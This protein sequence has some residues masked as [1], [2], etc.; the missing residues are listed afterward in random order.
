MRKVIV[1]VD[2]G[3]FMAYRVTK[4]PFA[5]SVQTELIES[6][7]SIEAR[8]KLSDTLSDAAGRFRLGQGKNGTVAGYGEAHNIELEKEK[9]L[10][11]QIAEDINALI[12][13]EKC[14]KWYLA[15]GRSINSQIVEN[16]EPAVRAKLD[17]NIPCNLTKAG[18]SGILRHFGKEAFVY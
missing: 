13:R 5:K 6:Y 15:A 14:E 4:D 12:T 16:L 10:V 7:D 11:K 18:R 9:R 3:H 2:L 8:L 1:V 17:R